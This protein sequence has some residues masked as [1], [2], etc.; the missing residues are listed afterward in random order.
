MDENELSFLI[1]GA[2][3]KVHNSLGPGLLESVYERA[4][5]YKLRSLGM[6]IKT[7]IGIPMIYEEVHFDCGFRLDILVN[8]LVIIEVKSVDI[9]MDIHHKQLLTYL[10]LMNKKLGLLMNFNSISLNKTSMVRIVNN[11]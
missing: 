5:A 3:F 8:N 6:E 7:Q 9:L 11:L 1:I 2:A 4:L 10:K